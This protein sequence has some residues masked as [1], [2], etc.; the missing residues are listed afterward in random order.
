[1]QVTSKILAQ[2]INT[3]AS[4]STDTATDDDSGGHSGMSTLHKV[5]LVCGCIVFSVLI[6]MIICKRR[7]VPAF[8]ARFGTKEEYLHGKEEARAESE[9]SQR[10]VGD[11]A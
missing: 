5:A 10:S 2:T 9:M 11:Q 1:M 8:V 6:S 3:L 4:N 7:I